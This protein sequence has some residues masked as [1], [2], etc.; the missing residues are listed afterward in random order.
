MSDHR[1][2]ARL[3][4]NVFQSALRAKIEAENDFVLA[5]DQLGK[6]LDNLIAENEELRSVA[7]CIEG[8][9]QMRTDELNALRIKLGLIKAREVKP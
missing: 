7:E 1:T 8:T 5:H 9:R 4:V 6:L 3:I 2:K